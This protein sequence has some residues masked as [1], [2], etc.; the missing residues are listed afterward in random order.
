MAVFFWPMQ[1]IS[2]MAMP[3]RIGQ[4]TCNDASDITCSQGSKSAVWVEWRDI[5]AKPNQGRNVEHPLGKEG[6][7]QM[8]GGDPSPTKHLLGHPVI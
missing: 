4:D 6:N 3:F 7:T 8:S 5:P 1:F 2:L